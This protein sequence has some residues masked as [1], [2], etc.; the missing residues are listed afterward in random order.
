MS[1]IYTF[2]QLY[3]YRGTIYGEGTDSSIAFSEGKTGNASIKINGQ[4]VTN[5]RVKTYKTDAETDCIVIKE[6]DDPD[7][8]LSFAI[9]PGSS[10][11][12]VTTKDEV[13]LP[14]LEAVFDGATE[15]EIEITWDDEAGK[16]KIQAYP[17]IERSLDKIVDKLQG[18][19]IESYKE[20]VPSIEYSMAKIADLIGSGSQ[21]DEESSAVLYDHNNINRYSIMGR[22]GQPSMYNQIY[23]NLYGSTEFFDSLINT[24]KT[25]PLCIRQFIGAL[26]L[27]S[28]N[29]GQTIWALESDVAYYNS[30]LA[31]LYMHILTSIIMA[32]TA[33]SRYSA[34]IVSGW[35]QLDS[36]MHRDY[37]GLTVMAMKRNSYELERIMGNDIVDEQNPTGTN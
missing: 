31:K 5:I 23:D 19:A 37:S 13:F 4:S 25:S 33:D 28:T 9:Y 11:V 7:Q 6:T 22:N 8:P 3:T 34:Y 18:T 12:C 35:L 16:P 24:L 14:F 36:N 29:Y 17:S 15:C 26:S 20:A 21:D 30:D 10:I 27:T 1:E 32:P 2:E